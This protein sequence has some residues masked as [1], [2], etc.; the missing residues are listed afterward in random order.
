MA[1]CLQPDKQDAP[2]TPSFTPSRPQV[3]V[4]GTYRTTVATVGSCDRVR[5]Y[6]VL[7]KDVGISGCAD[8]TRQ[9]PD[10]RRSNPRTFCRLREGPGSTEAGSSVSPPH[11]HPLRQLINRL[12]FLSH[13]FAFGFCASSVSLPLFALFFFKDL[14]RL[15][16]LLV[17]SSSWQSSSRCSQSWFL[18]S[19]F[20]QIVFHR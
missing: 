19:N 17:A 4:Q 8:R 11:M 1:A 12:L 7:R 10:L 14:Q 2:P 15:C 9:N 20:V 3:H 6:S 13:L 5:T 18:C 16:F